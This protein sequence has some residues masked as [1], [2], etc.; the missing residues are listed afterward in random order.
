MN[1]TLPPHSE[2]SPLNHVVSDY[3][4]VGLEVDGHNHW[5]GADI[6]LNV[7]PLGQYFLRVVTKDQYVNE[8]LAGS[9]RELNEIKPA[10]FEEEP[11]QEKPPYVLNDKFLNDSILTSKFVNRNIAADL[12]ESLWKIDTANGDET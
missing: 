11:L 3:E 5:V 4:V 6:V 12:A 1:N 9:L 2:E 10:L 8:N 7:Q